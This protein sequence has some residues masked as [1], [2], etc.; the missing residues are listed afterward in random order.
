[1]IDCTPQVMRLSVY[2]HKDLIEVPLPL[3]DLTHI[4]GPAD[5]DL[6]GKHRA[7]T[8]NPEPHALMADIDSAFVQQILDIA[9]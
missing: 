8:I 3:R 5:A 4:A 6:A 7:E 1:M 9:Q 2:L